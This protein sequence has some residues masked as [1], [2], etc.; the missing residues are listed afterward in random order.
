[1]KCV[2]NLSAIALIAFLSSCHPA[3]KSPSPQK[4][5]MVAPAAGKAAPAQPAQSAAQGVQNNVAPAPIPQGPAPTITFE[6]TTN[7]F[8]DIDPNSRNSTEFKFT[9][10]GKGTLKI[11]TIQTTCGCT[12]GTLSKYDYAPGESGAIK[13]EYH[14]SK[15]AG[16]VTKN[17]FVPSNDPNT[18]RVE[19]TLKGTIV[20]KVDVRPDALK[21]SLFEQNAGA[22]PVVLASK[23]GKAFAIK[24]ME[25]SA[26]VI[27]AKFDPNNYQTHFVI[28]LTVDT[29][30]L[31]SNLNGY[32][33][34]NI[35]HP[36]IDM[37]TVSYSTPTEFETQPSSIILRDAVAG[38]AIEREI[39]IKSN[40]DKD[41]EIESL[42]SKNGYVKVLKQDKIDH[43]Y[44]ILV[45]V[46][47]PEN[48]QT[49]FFSDTLDIKIKGSATLT[50]NCRGFYARKAK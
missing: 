10:T 32:V 41:F 28:P 39:W 6:K 30:K 14:A 34:F 17:L 21:L 9:N 47:A 18:P 38:A 12:V 27:T 8:G 23:D 13:V 40:Y 49:M 36:S 15:M 46:T 7:N 29:E 1:M 20:I 3:S 35:T 2:L 45:S 4:M 44:K 37:V 43:T 42:A 5:A 25:S 31:K 11:G 24:S 50:V 19:L 26:N 48:K 16:P 33:R 22:Q